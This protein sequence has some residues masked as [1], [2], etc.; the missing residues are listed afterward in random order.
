MKLKKTNIIIVLLVVITII[1]LVGENKKKEDENI[2]GNSEFETMQVKDLEMKYDEEKEETL[3]TYKIKNISDKEIAGQTINVMG[4]DENGSAAVASQIY[5]DVLEA[6]GEY[7]G[8]ITIIGNVTDLVKK[9]E[10]Q[11]PQVAEPQPEE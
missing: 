7:N 6:G 10:L 11:K 9:L 8:K 2:A 4:L 1:S 5:I 3:L